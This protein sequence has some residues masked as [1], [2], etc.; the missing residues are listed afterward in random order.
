MPANDELSGDDPYADFAADQTAPLGERTAPDKDTSYSNTRA[1]LVTPHNLSPDADGN[2][3]FHN[4]AK[5]Q[6]QFPVGELAA[7]GTAPSATGA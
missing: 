6:V 1:R 2:A 3:A 4:Q 5:S 7:R